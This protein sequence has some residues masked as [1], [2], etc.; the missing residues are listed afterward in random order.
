MAPRVS[1]RQGNS[2]GV[3]LPSPDDQIII[4]YSELSTFRQCP[5]KHHFTYQRR[6]TKPPS[7]TGALAKGSLWHNVLEAHYKVLKRSATNGKPRSD[8]ETNRLL[9]LCRKAVEPWL[10][11]SDG[12][13]TE[14]QALITWM[15]NGYVDRWGVNDNWKIVGVEHQI[16]YPL[17]M[18][19]GKPSRFTLKAKIDLFIQRLDI[20]TWWIVDHKS[21]GDLP[22]DMDLDLDDQFGL[23]GW[24]ANKVGR[25][26]QG[27]LHSAARTTQN[28]GDLPE[29]ANDPKCKPQPLEKR[30][31]HTF[32]ARTQ[33][34]LKN[35][36][37]DAYNAANAAYPPD[38]V[39]RSMYSSPNPRSCGFMCDM[40]DAHLAMRTGTP[41]DRAMKDFG[42]HV[43]FTRH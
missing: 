20:G 18:P 7:P 33:I 9:R 38:G 13:Q 16:Q 43:D 15:Y 2:K 31:A 41:P 8:K 4:S 23:Y 40:R 35:I 32:M 22:K 26:V 42:F 27:T 14:I 24:A 11:E 34:E 6:F 10:Y 36:A 5:M 28:K 17:P 21:C 39:V 30:F 25:P 1:G 3:A 29:H 19:N 37:L 12:T